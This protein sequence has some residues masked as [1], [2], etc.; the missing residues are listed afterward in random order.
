LE[1]IDFPQSAWMVS[2]S[3][4]QVKCHECISS[5]EP[6]DRIASLLERYALQLA[7]QFL[8]ALVAT[9]TDF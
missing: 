3:I 1:T 9:A 6:A 8:A 5:F 7:P 2:W 4:G